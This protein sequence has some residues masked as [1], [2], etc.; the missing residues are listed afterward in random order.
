[1]VIIKNVKKDKLFLLL[2]VSVLLLLFI[3]VNEK[4]AAA[5]TIANQETKLT[6]EEIEGIA[7]LDYTFSR[8]KNYKK[9][10]EVETLTLN[11]LKGKWAILYFWTKNCTPCINSFPKLDEIQMD[12]RSEAQVILV[13]IKDMWNKN[14]EP[15]FEGVKNAQK[16][17]LPIAY[18]SGLVNRL[19]II[20]SST[21]VIINPKGKIES[22]FLSDS[23]LKKKI[24]AILRRR[25]RSKEGA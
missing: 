2:Q 14:I 3:L 21:V 15:Y 10:G 11:E 4:D 17:N 12:Y 9:N 22:I 25:F 24:K 1:M 7:I 8:V 19:G 18:D 5:Q 6:K 13:G 23:Q 16:I 20:Y